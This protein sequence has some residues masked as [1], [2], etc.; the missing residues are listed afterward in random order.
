MGAGSA[1]PPQNQDRSG[2]THGT[3]DGQGHLEELRVLRAGAHPPP[4]CL[5][6][7]GSFMGGV[8][9]ALTV[10]PSGK[11]SRH[12]PSTGLGGCPR[13]GHREPGR[14]RQGWGHCPEA[15]EASQR[16]CEESA[17]GP[18]RQ[19]PSPHPPGREVGPR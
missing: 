13:R 5:G 15:G 9:M 8:E 14:E 17:K 1:A 2:E 6:Q 12:P 7:Q 16:V 19:V 3:A 10:G 11:G 18:P 4:A